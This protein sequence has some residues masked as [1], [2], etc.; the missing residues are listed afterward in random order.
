MRANPFA[1]L[2]EPMKFKRTTYQFGGVEKKRR[3]H[4]SDV[5]VY[6]FRQPQPDGP[7][8]HR[9]RVIGTVEQY[10][11]KKLAKKAAEV[12]RL[13]ANPDN[14]AQH[15]VSWGALIDRYIA[16]ELPPRK[17]TSRT[18]RGI[19]TNYVRPKWGSY[20]LA[21]VKIFAV[22]EWLKQIKHADGLLDLAPKT[23]TH[24]RSLMH[25]LY[26]F[27]MR[28]ELV[29]LSIN[30]FGK[31]LVRIKNASKRLKK[32][33]SLRVEQ[34]HLLVEHKLIAQ[35][36]IRTMVIAAICL[37]LRCSELFA[38]RWSD[39]DWEN[40]AINVRRGVV[41]GVF[42]KPKSEHSEAPVPLAAELA[43]VFWNWKLQSP[44]NNPD[45]FVFAS[46]FT[47]GRTPYDP[48]GLQRDRLLP[49][50]IEIGFG[51]GLGWHNFRHTYRTLLDEVKAPVSVQ[52]ELMRHADSRT[53]LE[54]GEALTSSKRKANRK[55]VRLILPEK[56]RRL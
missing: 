3:K 10:P 45:D 2:E 56:E 14:P 41:R 29:P 28:W 38:L 8:Q 35:E 27:A 12:F 18:Y 46:P 36:P 48:Y 6:R 30:P 19:L 33:P 9:S 7:V 1:E 47:G 31:R 21:G 53:T 11:T 26:D 23:K 52:Q 39:F 34:F 50:G 22:E 13:A 24:I 49:A 42:D 51:D 40:L 5:W 25:I 54:Y 37:G 55:V 32:R 4:G 17:S 16:E 20:A 43:E 44:F 15:G